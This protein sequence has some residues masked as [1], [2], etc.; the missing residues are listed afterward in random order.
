[1]TIPNELLLIASTVFVYSMLLLW[2]RLFG[3]R[4]VCA[5]SVF[6]SVL[7]NIE[8][9]ILVDAFGIEMTLGNVLFASTFLATDIL[10]EVGGK[11]EAKRCVDLGI[12]ASLTML[13][14]TQSWM[15]YTP[16]AND[17]AHPAIRTVFSGTPRL[18][19]VSLLVYALVQRVDVALFHFIWRATEKRSGSRR[20]FLWLRN[21]LA[22]M[23]SQL[24]NA[25]LYTLGAF[26]GM[27]SGKT[28]VSIMLS[29]YLIFLFTSLADTPFVYLARRIHEKHPKID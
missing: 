22:T 11:D 4:G 2:F 21:N 16:N 10:S 12:A 29:S 7:A 1:M 24:L 9:L 5:F 13:V 26:Y 23:I 25:V 3:T 14:V 20:A 19:L 28:L 27:Y 8:V 6:A 15:L 18:L 17:W